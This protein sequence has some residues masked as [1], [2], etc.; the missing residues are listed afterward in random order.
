MTSKVICI[1]DS[2][3]SFFSG[4]NALS[5]KYPDK[6]K[7][8]NAFFEAYRIGSVLA[9][10]LIQSNTTE[11]GSEKILELLKTIPKKSVLLF[12]FGEID[13]RCHLI[14]QSIK[15]NKPVLFV[16]REC[17][18]RYLDFIN[19]IV[20]LDFKVIV[21]APTPTSNNYDPEYPYYGTMEERNSC[22][23]LF[24]EI[25]Q[26]KCAQFAMDYICIN[27]YLINKKGLTKSEYFFDA[28]HLSTLSLVFVKKELFRLSQFNNKSFIETVSL[29]LNIAFNVVISKLKKIN[30]YIRSSVLLKH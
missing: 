16:V 19:Q 24:N 14:K 26:K 15:Q 6:G 9:Y 21:L 25:L 17:V 1:G 30:R 27:K 22:T 13:I 20:L 29:E 18:E 8:R 5:P 11:R 12:C 3:V 7:N 4:Y 23:I 2:H 10:N 28:L